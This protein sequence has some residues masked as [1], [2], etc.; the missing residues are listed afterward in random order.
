MITKQKN[1]I[2]T[3]KNKST[4][5]LDKD[6]T[7]EGWIRNNRVGKAVS[8]LVINDGSGL[9]ELQIV[10]HSKGKKQYDYDDLQKW[11][12]GSA[13]VI[14]GKLVV[15]KN[16]IEKV[17]L[18]LKNIRLINATETDYFLQKKAHNLEFL[19]AHSELR[20]RSRYFFS[21]FRIRNEL[22]K[23]I[24]TFFQ[25]ANYH[26]L[27]SPVITNNDCEGGGESF[28]LNQK[29][30]F[31]KTALLSVSG[32]L[33]AEGMAQAFKKV[34]TF[35]PTFRAD[36]SNTR[37]HASEFW[38]LEPEIA[39]ATVKDGMK[40]VEDLIKSIIRQIQNNMKPEINYL[41][42]Q[43][44]VNLNERLQKLIDESFLNLT[45]SEAIK[46]LKKHSE[47][48]EIKEVLWG[49]DLQK[50]HEKFLCE[51][52]NAPVF[53]T[54]YPK[55]IKA[56]YMKQNNDGKTVACF[57]LLLAGIGEIVGG[58][59]REN[60]FEKL[61]QACEA[62]EIFSKESE[63]YLNLRKQGFAGSTG[64]GLGFDRLLMYLTGVQNIRDVI[65]FYSGFGILKY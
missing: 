4:L 30:F 47:K 63:W 56:F 60:D 19:R 9:E 44:N 46:M 40:I 41:S 61:K 31:K 35:G 1:S 28:I 26:Y 8:F 23:A 34:Y 5:Y 58:S 59:E 29:S 64:F 7:V 62:K 36:K 14:T 32:Q 25:N 21:I 6:I 11:P 57:D 24:H 50:E 48:F 33:H 15:A 45:Y 22:T 17:E 39:F 54:D 43:N 51:K 38:M 55:Q 52:M 2:Y 10:Y 49:I 27:Q 65:P 53:I 18:L 42:E 12:V 37:F 20:A 3:L 16:E 13:V